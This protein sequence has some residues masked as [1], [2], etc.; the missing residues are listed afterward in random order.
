MNAAVSKPFKFNPMSQFQM[1]QI[2]A[3]AE[4]G[5][6][7]AQFLL[8]QICLQ[9]GDLDN[10][11]RWL[12][13][14]SANKHPDAIGAL[15][16]CFE[17][18]QGVA[19]DL[20]RALEHYDQAIAAGAKIAALQKAQLLHKSKSGVKNSRLIRELLVDAAKADVVPALRTVGYLAMQN[21][22]NRT[23]AIDCLRRAAELGDPVS[24]FNL[25]WCLLQGYSDDKASG[26]ARHWLQHAA[27]AN[28][29]YAATL[30]ASIDI[31]QSVLS[32]P[33]SVQNIQFGK[34]FALYP[35]DADVERKVISADPPIALL[36]DVLDLVDSAYL[37]FVSRPYLQR[38]AVIDPDDIDGGKKGM[39]SNV[40][41]SMS[42]Y[43]PFELVDVISRYIELKI[44]GAADEE[45][46]CSEPMSILCYAPGEFYRPHFDFFNPRLEIAK[47]LMQD[48]GQRTASAITYLSAPTA[49]GGTSF[50]NLSLTVPA[51]TGSTLWF[52]NCSADGQ[53]DQR[54]LHAGDTVEAG[55]KWV[56][57]KWF[58]EKPTS[59]L[60]L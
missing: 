21:G 32:A 26:E 9:D 33:S 36:Q 28:Y 2:V 13:Q 7:D 50:P 46:I 34:E 52:R 53:V 14:A 47:K 30:L 20:P 29:P 37:M 60:K 16:Q 35:K 45:L 40:R 3:D 5:K 19:Q 57:T 59:Y 41:T 51:A 17:R 54:S 15:G 4:A 1:Q 8:S 25:G 56:V 6:P 11:L 48:G 38:A 42:T 44:I 10:M 27:T 18:G 22:S 12:H 31:G 49:G 24:S 43:I 39:V 55:E 23:L 58:R